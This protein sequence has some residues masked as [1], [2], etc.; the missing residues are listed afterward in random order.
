M[1]GL[2]SA[3]AAS[4]HISSVVISCVPLGQLLV[5]TSPVTKPFTDS[6]RQPAGEVGHSP[7][8]MYVLPST[9]AASL[10]ISSVVIESVP[11]GQLLVFA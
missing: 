5:S 11:S 3:I 9:V 8:A 2:P 10:H 1:Y 6:T 4:L 7:E